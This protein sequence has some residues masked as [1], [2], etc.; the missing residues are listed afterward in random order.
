MNID[1]ILVYLQAIFICLY[2][3]VGFI[4]S[5]Y[6][7]KSRWLV[8]LFSYVTLTALGFFFL[9]QV[10]ENLQLILFLL[11]AVSFTFATLG[12]SSPRAKLFLTSVLFFLSCGLLYFQFENTLLWISTPVAFVVLFIVVNRWKGLLEAAR[13]YFLR[14]GMLVTVLFML[15]PMFVSVQQNLKPVPTIPISSIINQ[16]N[17]LLLGILILLM[18]GGFFWKEK[19]SL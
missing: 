17:F 12:F 2:G 8:L 1:L 11:L 9:D 15:E 13:A 16:H 7:E 3:V 6:I 10:K 18:L 4:Q 5:K 14:A 19:S